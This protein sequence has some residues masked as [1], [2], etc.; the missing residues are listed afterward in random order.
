MLGLTPTLFLTALLLTTPP[1]QPEAE[2]LVSQAITALEAGRGAEAYLLFQTAAQ[3]APQ[4]VEIR[5]G[6]GVV[7]IH[8]GHADVARKSLSWVLEQNPEHVDARFNLGKLLT[9]LG[10]PAA[11]V[12][13]FRVVLQQR[14]DDLEARLELVSALIALPDNAA[15]RRELAAIASPTPAVHS[16]RSFVALRE[17]RWDDALADARAALQAEPGALRH[18]LMVATALLHKG[19]TDEA[20]LRLR[21]LVREAPASQANVPYTLGLA[22]FLSGDAHTA[23]RWIQEA[24]ARAPGMFDPSSPHFVQAAF[25]TSRDAAFLGWAQAHPGAP[26]APEAYLRA[27]TTEGANCR[28]GP[29]MQALLGKA[30]LLQGCFRS[31]PQPHRVTALVRTSLSEVEVV[32]SGPVAACI[33]RVLSNVSVSQEPGDCAITVRVE[34]A[35]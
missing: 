15:A 8:T 23:R 22:A 9:L 28:R 24:G 26:R 5:Y 4:N 6:L 18:R 25:P 12:P 29:L 17:R 31:A 27:L 20:L 7:A 32:P 16:L 13:H 35:R 1:N 33:Q 10:E 2:A 21:R 11:A 34:S 14:P 30:T 19:E 3:K